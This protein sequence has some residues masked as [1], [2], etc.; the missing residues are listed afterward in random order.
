MGAGGSESREGLEAWVFFLP[1]SLQVSPCCPLY[2][3][4][5]V[6]APALSPQLPAPPPAPPLA[7]QFISLYLPC[8]LQLSYYPRD[9]PMTHHFR[10][11]FSI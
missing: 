2:K 8:P 7:H 10:A 9:F 1:L 4:G 3:G 5:G 11:A 6:L